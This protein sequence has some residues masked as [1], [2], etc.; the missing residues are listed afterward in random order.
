M[1]RALGIRES[2]AKLRLRREV[3]HYTHSKAYVP[4]DFH[5]LGRVFTV[6]QDLYHQ[7]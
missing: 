7:Q 2:S 3:L 1:S 4:Y 6:L 5:S